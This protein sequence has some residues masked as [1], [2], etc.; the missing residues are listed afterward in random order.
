[1][2]KDLYSERKKMRKQLKG[3]YKKEY[4]SLLRLL[5]QDM[6]E[7]DKMQEVDLGLLN[8]FVSAQ[9]EGVSLQDLY[10]G[11]KEEF[12]LTLLIESKSFSLDERLKMKRSER[13]LNG[14][15]VLILLA[16]LLFMWIS[17]TDFYQIRKDGFLYLQRNGAVI[18]EYEVL[19]DEISFQLNIKNFYDN[20]NKVIY[21]NEYGKIILENV[22]EENG[23]YILNFR[24]EGILDT[25]GSTLVSAVRHLYQENG[26]SY[27]VMNA[28]CTFELDHR[29]Y[30]CSSASMSG[31]DKKGD[32]FSFELF[33]VSDFV[34][35]EF[36]EKELF[37][38]EEVIQVTLKDLVKMK[39]K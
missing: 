3:L 16:A 28:T 25:E 7:N 17:Y 4:K 24:S 12:Y 35:G 27:F 30:M 34:Q 39:W 14:W 10:G 22:C 11:S 1:M 36:K 33:S 18:Q 21:E 31:L 38:S 32:T 9:K 5:V 37:E 23:N 26:A 29:T 8:L 13:F 19:K 2:D 15:M 6:A 20:S